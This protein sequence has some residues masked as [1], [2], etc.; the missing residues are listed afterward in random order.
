MDEDPTVVVRRIKKKKRVKGAALSF[1]DGDEDEEEADAQDETT[2]SAFSQ[3]KKKSSKKRKRKGLGFGGAPVSHLDDDDAM[4]TTNNNNNMREQPQDVEEKKEAPAY[5]KEALEKLK[6]EQ[7][8]LKP[9]VPKEQPPLPK[10]SAD[11]P[12]PPSQDSLPSYIPLNDKQQMYDDEPAILTGEQ[13]M[14][15]QQPNGQHDDDDDDNDMAPDGQ[16]FASVQPPEETNP[17]WEA[18]ITRRAGLRPTSSSNKQSS[19]SSSLIPSL[20]T[21]RQQLQSTLHNLQLQQEDLTNATMRRQAELAQTQS[22]AKRHELAVQESGT[23]LNDYQQLRQ[24]LVVWVGGLRDLSEKVQPIFM[25]VQEL[26]IQQHTL[27]LSKWQ[28]WQ[29]D[30]ASILRDAQ[31][32]DQVLGRQAVVLPCTTSATLEG[33]SHVDEFGRDIQSQDLRLREKR[34]R[35]RVVQEE[36]SS[37]SSSRSMF[38]S[39]GERR[40]YRERYHALKEAL[41]VALE[42]LQDE[43]TSFQQLTKMFLG[44][45]TSHAEEYRQ[46]YASL[47]LGDLAAVLVKMDLCRSTWLS[48]MLEGDGDELSSNDNQ[49]QAELGGLLSWVSHLEIMEQDLREGDEGPIPRVLEKSLV[50]FLIALLDDPSSAFCWASATKSRSLSQCITRVMGLFQKKKNSAPHEVVLLLQKALQKSTKKALESMT[51][52]IVKPRVKLDD[53]DDEQVAHALASAKQGQVQCLQ[54]LL[55]HILT[56][57]VPVTD[58]NDNEYIEA[59]LDFLSSKFLFLLSSLSSDQASTLFSPIWKALYA[60]QHGR[61]WLLSPMWMLQAAPIRGA[62]VAYGLQ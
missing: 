52:S 43:Y 50:P 7:K 29:D 46:C 49:H 32:L 5:G 24:D 25:L 26:L 12:P 56:Q 36:S 47:S 11:L 13:A 55:L 21:L 62:A 6:A 2:S 38:L 40:D 59:I 9:P 45:K 53:H 48:A 20:D 15:L 31:L 4:D 58:H 28:E 22:D 30:V 1:G 17:E 57:V 54:Q 8:N 51:I 27:A 37:S 35:Q 42:E 19:S 41:G 60:T 16:H 34:Y 39:I 23:A 14:K 10:T 33:S 18:E 3:V 44:W 61:D